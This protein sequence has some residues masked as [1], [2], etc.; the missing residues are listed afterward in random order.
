VRIPEHDRHARLPLGHVSVV[1]GASSGIG[2]STAELLGRHGS[3]VVL[4]GRDAARLHATADVVRAAG[5]R[6]DVVT[7]D[8]SRPAHVRR[9]A[10][11]IAGTVDGVDVLVNNAAS[12]RRTRSRRPTGS[13][14]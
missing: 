3:H 12:S 2:A 8:L 14:P 1:T 13:T 5:A 9:A 4:L 10:A 11:R 7:A 6:A